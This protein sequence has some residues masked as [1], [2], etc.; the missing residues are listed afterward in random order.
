MGPKRMEEAKEGRAGLPG[1]VPAGRAIEGQEPGARAAGQREQQ[2]PS[3]I[4]GASKST[5]AR[6]ASMCSH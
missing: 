6:V 5:A 4:R 1:E 2:L 3:E